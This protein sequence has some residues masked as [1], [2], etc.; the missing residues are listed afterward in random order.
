MEKR[1]LAVAAAAALLFGLV[2]VA[3]T[4]SADTLS[5]GLV[6]N[7][8]KDSDYHVTCIVSGCPRVGNYVVDHIHS[9]IGVAGSANTQDE[10][11]FDCIHGEKA[12]YGISNHNDRIALGLQACRKEFAE[13]DKCTPYSNYTYTPPGPA[14]APAQPQAG[15][16][17]APQVPQTAHVT[18][19]DMPVFNIA[20][21]DVK[22]PANGVQGL[23][24]ATLPNAT[25]VSFDGPCKS[26]WC[27]IKSPLIPNGVGFAEEKS[28]LLD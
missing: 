6:V 10:Q 22:D 12:N 3:P 2:L 11:S 18:G 16:T 21:D 7:C 23:K 24:V 27:R 19:G 1:F 9:M 15:P 25:I 5:N 28:L 26:G 13:P 20:H 14:P 4:A 8:T 17:Y